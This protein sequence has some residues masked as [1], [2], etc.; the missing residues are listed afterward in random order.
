MTFLSFHWFSDMFGKNE[1]KT[2]NE[3]LLSN[4][5]YFF[6]NNKFYAELILSYFIDNIKKVDY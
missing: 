5:L 4:R 1:K 3:I 6:S 2:E